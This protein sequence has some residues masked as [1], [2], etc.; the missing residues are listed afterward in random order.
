MSSFDDEYESDRSRDSR[1]FADRGGRGQGRGQGRGR[2]LGRGRGERRDAGRERGAGSGGGWDEGREGGEGY[3]RYNDERP[4]YRAG[5]DTR[6][7]ST[8]ARGGRGGGRG[9]SSSFDRRGRGGGSTDDRHAD[10]SDERG[11]R[12]G[13]GGRGGGDRHFD[14]NTQGF[15]RARDPRMRDRGGGRGGGGG[16]G[17]FSRDGGRQLSVTPAQPQ[18]SGVR[19]DS[20]DFDWNCAACGASN[21]A[22][23]TACFRCGAGQD[24]TAAG[25][26]P[27][28]GNVANTFADDSRGG[29][30]R[31]KSDGDAREGRGG[32]S[33]RSDVYSEERGGRGGDS[34]DLSRGGLVDIGDAAD[35][36]YAAGAPSG[37]GREQVHSKP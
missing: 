8:G 11:Y 32:G 33:L 24:E 27:G 17:G 6:G 13:D 30:G 21:F 16:D 14:D 31:G 5:A 25:M 19:N 20:G 2:S 26:G 34:W 1:Q 36:G 35:D 22:R 28:V 29:G 3:A 10:R 9:G 4:S 23:R 15:P 7:A 18:L 37:R 12:G